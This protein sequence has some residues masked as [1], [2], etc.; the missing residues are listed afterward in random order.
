M[1]EQDVV[2]LKRTV[3]SGGRSYAAGACGTIKSVDSAAIPPMFDVELQAAEGQAPTRIKLTQDEVFPAGDV[4]IFQTAPLSVVSIRP[5][6]R[7]NRDVRVEVHAISGN[8]NGS[9]YISTSKTWLLF[10]DI[11]DFIEELARLQA[12]EINQTA[13]SSATHGEFAISLWQRHGLPV[14]TVEI[15][16]HRQIQNQAHEDKLSFAFE[17]NTTVQDVIDGFR[18]LAF[19][20]VNV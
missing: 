9:T 8:P 12:K 5:L 17:L 2:R 20:K 16:S 13:L 11:V 19:E 18:K 3:T 7:L 15:G 4:E 1:K 14:V 10:Q 6:E